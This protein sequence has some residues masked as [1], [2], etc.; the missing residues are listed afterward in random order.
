[1]QFIFFPSSWQLLLYV[2]GTV[3]HE[4]ITSTPCGFSGAYAPIIVD[5]NKRVWIGLDVGLAGT[6]FEF[7]LK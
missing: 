6:L 1:M 7:L 3:L 4:F 5:N 2:D